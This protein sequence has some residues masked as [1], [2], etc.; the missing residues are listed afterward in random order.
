[1]NLRRFLTILLVFNLS[2][3][4]LIGATTTA[5]EYYQKAQE[6]YLSQK[7]YDAI[8]EL[9]E[10]VKINPNYYEAYKFIAEIYYLLKIYNQAQFFMEKAYRMSN[11]DI[12]YK[13]LYANIL[14][15]NNGMAQAKKF[16]SEVISKQ[17][18]NIDALV[19]LA[20]IFEGK[21]C[22]LQLLITIFLFLNTIRQIIMPLSVLW[23]FMRNWI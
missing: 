10:A 4:S 13:I 2:F 3:G 22:L 19:G 11:G 9:L 5:I 12:E 20:S 21:G 16:Y 18:N 23:V 17:K 15:K 14:L 6:C 8:D 7:Y 1:M